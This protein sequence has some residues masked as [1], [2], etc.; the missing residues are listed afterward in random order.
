MCALLDIENQLECEAERSKI[1]LLGD[2]Q[3]PALTIVAA[4]EPENHLSPHLFGRAIK[5]L[6][7]TANLPNAQVLIS[8]HTA[9]VLKRIEPESIRY[10]RI[11]DQHRSEVFPIRLMGTRENVH[12]FVREAVRAYPELYFAKL[13][14]LVEG[15]SEDIV[16]SRVLEAHHSPVDMAQISIVPIGG[17]HV[18]HFWRLLNELGIPHVTLLDLDRG[19]KGGGWGRVRYA[20]KQLHFLHHPEH[21]D[22]EATNAKITIKVKNKTKVLTKDDLDEYS[23]K[24]TFEKGDEL[25][26][27]VMKLR[28]HNVF[29]SSPLDLDFMML[30]EFPDHYKHERSFPEG[31]GPD[32]P[33][34]P[35]EYNE[36]LAQAEKS[37]LKTS[38]TSAGYS[39]ED[40]ELFIHYDYLFLGRGK[41][42]TH[43]I[44]LSELSNDEL[45]NGLPEPL[46]A[47]I[48]RVKEKLKRTK[49]HG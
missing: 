13:V 1:G 24:K 39:A 27:C 49:H 4:E 21:L 23:R 45:R 48:A 9:S 32:I 11:N 6:T 20:V 35:D 46:S 17:R 34:D 22:K 42:V 5:K 14:I 16:L 7:A 31:Q 38:G 36:K 43:M 2:L 44:A 18:N 19:R 37:V 3:T 26:A 12:K 47:L 10:L 15:E 33:T 30:S 41:P 40:K 29:F 8:S 28:E 25:D